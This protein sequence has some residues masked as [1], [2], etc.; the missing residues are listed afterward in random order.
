M[1]KIITC[2]VGLVAASALCLIGCKKS[3]CDPTPDDYND[4]LCSCPHSYLYLQPFG[5]FKKG[6]AERIERDIARQMPILA[7]GLGLEIKILNPKPLPEMAYSK[8]YGRYRADS[9]LTYENRTPQK[10]GVLMGLLHEDIS[11]SIHGQKDFGII[12]Y[13]LCPGRVSVVST[14][15]VPVQTGFTWLTVVHEY[16]HTQGVPH[17][18]NNDPA[19]IMCD[20]K[21]HAPSY[22]RMQGLCRD[23][24]TKAHLPIYDEKDKYIK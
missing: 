1:K 12:G 9:L 17:C 21:G 3:Q 19:C 16:L 23:C 13:S 22:R 7:D 24:A 2:L 5:D 14:H 11:T 8:T 18:P 6:E 4:T 15:R 20:A 10:D